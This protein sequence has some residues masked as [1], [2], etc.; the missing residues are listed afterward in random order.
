VR[1]QRYK[2]VLYQTREEE[3][4][5]LKLDPYELDNRASSPSLNAVKERLRAR[6][7][8]LCKPRPPGYTALS[9]AS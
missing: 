1:S 9:P 6:L 2:Y 3:L 5:D 4:Y 7:A 8:V